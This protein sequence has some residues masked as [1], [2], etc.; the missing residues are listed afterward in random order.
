ML[1]S[2]LHSLTEGMV[3]AVYE[4]GHKIILKLKWFNQKK[5]PPLA[6]EPK[7]NTLKSWLVTCNYKTLTLKTIIIIS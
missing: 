5:K 4:R 3:D 7:N 2:M 1:L 6:E